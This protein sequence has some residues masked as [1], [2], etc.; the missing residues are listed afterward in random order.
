MV[1]WKEKW[2]MQFKK[3]GEMGGMMSVEVEW[4]SV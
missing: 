3:K 4:V 1:E 2:E